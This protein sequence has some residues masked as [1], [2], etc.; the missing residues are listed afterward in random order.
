MFNIQGYYENNTNE[1]YCKCC[2][3]INVHAGDIIEDFSLIYPFN[4][5]VKSSGAQTYKPN[6][7]TIRFIKN[8]R[9]RIWNKSPV[10]DDDV[11]N[12]DFTN[13]SDD[14]NRDFLQRMR[15]D[16]YQYINYEQIYN[17]GWEKIFNIFSQNNINLIEDHILKLKNEKP[18]DKT[19]SK[20]LD[21]L[22]DLFRFIS[23]DNS[24]VRYNPLDKT[25]GNDMI[26]FFN[27]ELGGIPYI[28]KPKMMQSK[29]S[30]KR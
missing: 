9:T 17:L 27:N 18:I 3:N 13:N 15:W 14:F 7:Q 28:A 12:Y 8:K 2:N 20:L 22:K 1:T 25:S 24:K 30:Y 5:N 16:Q 23:Y 26:R 21:K 29:T 11:K 6:N 19:D 10:T 4:E